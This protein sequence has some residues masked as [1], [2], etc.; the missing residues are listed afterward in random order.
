MSEAAAN[1]GREPGQG[2]VQAEAGPFSARTVIALVIAAVFAFSALTVLQAYA[3]DL[4]GGSDGGAHALSRSAIGFSGLT[5]LLKGLGEPV[6][7]S[8]DPRVRRASTSLLVLT[9]EPDS[10]AREVFDMS[11]VGP[12]LVV[13]P[14]WAALPD[15]ANPGWAINGGL[16]APGEAA[17]PLARR[18]GKVSLSADPAT[19]PA[20]LT[21]LA[22]GD[23]AT[24]PVAQLQTLAG[25]AGLVPVL[26]DG[27]GRTVLART[28]D[29][30]A[31][32]LSDPDLLNTHGLKDLAT[33]RAAVAI[34]GAVRKGDGPIVFDVTLDGFSRSRNLLKLAFSPPFLGATLCLA[35]AALLGGVQAAT[36]FGPAVRSGRAIAL[37]KRALADN[38]AG[39]IRLARREPAMAGRYLDLTR[40]AVA[41]ALGA[42]AAGGVRL[43]ASE[44]TAVLDRQAERLGTSH[45]LAELAAQAETVKDR[46]AL[47][48]LARDLRQWRTEMTGERR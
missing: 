25:G 2:A 39:L 7:V 30:R 38:S 29:G 11:A 23:L 27:R 14:K 37:G 22:A 15:P 8:R 3:P 45:R 19:T 9:P 36:R 13:A 12:T 28:A 33:A 10:S 44:L 43:G 32:L 6:V 40:S 16:L 31:Y 41:R 21:G 24:G 35:A 18:F 42:E 4:R 1:Q 26:R 34:V 5:R 17:R 46:A 48:R 20:R 47:L